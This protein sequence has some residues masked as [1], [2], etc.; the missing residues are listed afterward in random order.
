LSP[1]TG[2]FAINLKKPNT[3]SGLFL[4]STIH[5]CHEGEKANL[6]AVNFV[7]SDLVFSELQ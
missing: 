7:A 6:A 1:L 3:A 5:S 4:C 2:S